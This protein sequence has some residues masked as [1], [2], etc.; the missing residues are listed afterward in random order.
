M[1][2]YEVLVIGAGASGIGAAI[3]LQEAG[4]TDFAVL[5][6]S[7]AL[8]G[9]WRD[10]TYPGCACDV[11]SALYSYSFAPNPG[12][13]RAFA[14]QPEIRAYLERTAREHGV[15]PFI[16]FGTEVLEA[17]WD[18]TNGT[19]RLRTT[20][21]DFSATSL[22]AAAGP[23]HEPN[24][25]DVPGLDTFDGPVFHSSRWDHDVDLAG[26]RVGVIGTGA[27]AVQFVPEIA[28]SVARLEL[29]QRTPQWVLP[30]PDHY[31]SHAERLALDKVPGLRRGLRG[32]EY[33][34]MEAVGY[35]F[36]HPRLQPVLKGIGRAHIAAHI[37]DR[38]LR[39]KLTPDW[40]V[41][42]N[43]LLV[44]NNYYPALARPNV[45]LHAT[46]LTEARGNVVVGADGIEA[47][48]DVIIFGT[49]FRIL[50]MPMAERVFGTAGASLSDHWQGSPQ[51]YRGTTVAGFPNLFLVLGPSLGTAT[52][53]FVII[54]AQLE[55]TLGA[56][57]HL[58]A[59]GAAS[60]DVREQVQDA[61]NAR[62]QAALPATVFNSGG[63]QSYYFDSNGRNSFSWPWSTDRL[64]QML[65]TFDA[66]D[67]VVRSREHQDVS[68]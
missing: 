21:G 18:G 3:K 7:A 58:R 19:W 28:P 25:P 50:D 38:D 11:P 5:E 9:T 42:C 31:V 20:R 12:W 17:R 15:V 65:S 40:A 30:K 13:T 10:N 61:Y 62:V 24:M 44:S 41:G 22:I 35:A 2:H 1:T 14:G 33:A 54:E 36:R 56:L 53:A 59:T 29:F 27:S 67:Y 51:S 4:V 8:G 45:N 48:V 57:A 46:A 16:K 6:K 66:A 64:L 26:K 49:G 39:R 55:Y 63:C 52:S 37:R 47:E 32:S 23:W 34:S 60:V 68:V 43:R